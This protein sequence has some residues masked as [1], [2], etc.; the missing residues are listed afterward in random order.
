MNVDFGFT[1]KGN[2]MPGLFS[3]SAVRVLMIVIIKKS[4]AY[5]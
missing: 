3:M 5:A 1:L 4:C 2:N